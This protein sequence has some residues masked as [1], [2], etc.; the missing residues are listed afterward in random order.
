MHDGGWHFS[1]LGGIDKI[2]AKLE[3]FSHAELNRPEFRSDEHIRWAAENGVDLF[4]REG[5]FQFVELDDSYPQYVL[6]NPERFREYVFLPEG[7]PTR[8]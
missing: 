4:H 5:S 6:D 2:Q 7:K 8:H 3:A 1:Y